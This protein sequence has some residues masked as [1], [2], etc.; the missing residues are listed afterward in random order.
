MIGGRRRLE[1]FPFERN[2]SNGK[3]SLKI[4]TLEQALIEKVYQVFRSLL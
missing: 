1:R 3:K 4:K 2:C